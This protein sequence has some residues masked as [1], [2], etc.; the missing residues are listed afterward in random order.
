[1]NDESSDSENYSSDK[2][3]DSVDVIVIGADVQNQRVNEPC[4]VNEV[5][6]IFIVLFFF[7]VPSI[8]V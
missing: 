5:S 1:M 2:D 3:E 8:I 4:D 7:C 6:S